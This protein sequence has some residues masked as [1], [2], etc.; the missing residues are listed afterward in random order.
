MTGQ[1]PVDQADLIILNALQSDFPLAP[2]PWEDIGR[3]IGIS[4][5]EV[6][7]RVRQMKSLGIIRSISPTLESSKRKSRVSTLVALQVPNDRIED[8]AAVVNEYS[9]VSHNFRREGEFNLWFTLA[10]DSYEKI[11]RIVEEIMRKTGVE[12]DHLLDLTTIRAY[13]IDVTFPILQRDGD[14]H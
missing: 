4:G 12:P 8:V 7:R 13:K 11:D 6:L 1:L 2:N 9:E 3:S 5:E 10:A 14:D